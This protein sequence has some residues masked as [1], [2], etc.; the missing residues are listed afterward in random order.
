VVVNKSINLIGE[1]KSIT[2]VDGNNSKC[3]VKIQADW[4]NISKLTLQNGVPVIDI[5]SN[6]S[7]IKGNILKLR[8][9][10]IDMGMLGSNKTKCNTIIDNIFFNTAP[11]GSSGIDISDGFN[12]IVSNNTIMSSSYE[13][14]Y[15]YGIFLD[16][17]SDS[18]I[19]DNVISGGIDFYDI[20]ISYSSNNIISGNKIYGLNKDISYIAISLD[21]CNNCIVS[22]NHMT[23]HEFGIF[24]FWSDNN[25]IVVNSIKNNENGIIISRSR[26]NKVKQNNFINNDKNAFFIGLSI[27]NKWD[28]NYWNKSRTLPYCI[29]GRLVIFSPWINIDWHPASEPYDI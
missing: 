18:I 27:L 14:C 15:A 6:Y 21:V 23:N 12:H 10:G 17:A 3:V 7:T 13:Y 5:R 20:Q 29:I 9:V 24:I 26:F 16:N 11:F 22:G 19:S 8:A 1:D 4:V 25:Q 28:G 2:I